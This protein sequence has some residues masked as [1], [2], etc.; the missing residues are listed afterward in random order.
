ML[1]YDIRPNEKFY[2]AIFGKG[3]APDAAALA[4]ATDVWGKPFHRRWFII[5]GS[6]GVQAI[7]PAQP[8]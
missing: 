7:L 6:K 2:F 8:S 3:S 1:G 4:D 5:P